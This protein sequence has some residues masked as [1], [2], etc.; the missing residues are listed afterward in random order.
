MYDPVTVYDPIAALANIDKH[1][2]LIKLCLNVGAGLSFV[3]FFI[4]MRLAWTQKVYVVPFMAAAFFIWHD[5]S[6]VAHY[7]LWWDQYGAH[8]WLKQW[9]YAQ[10]G[11]VALE[12]FLVW[13]FWHYGHKELMPE[14]SKA[15]F[16][17]LVVAG[18][19]GIGA[20]WWL[21]KDAMGDELYLVSQI[22]SAV[23]PAIPFHTG[24]L[25]RRK[26]R[27]GN[28]IWM[29]VSIMLI[30]VAMSAVGVLAAPEF[31]T[32]PAFIAF[33]AVFMIWPVVN[34]WLILRYPPYQA[35]RCAS[36]RAPASPERV[37]RPGDTM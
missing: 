36:N 26:S 11:T 31:F 10:V 2:D 5:G 14:W 29:Q 22:V 32:R 34:V 13:Q 27:A 16:G 28:S 23:F 19:L 24:I 35:A 12:V 25:L 30:F 3:Y 18:T 17:G 4:G 33:F 37:P 8:W 21:F 7:P 1:K 15:A 20:I 6:Y 9:T